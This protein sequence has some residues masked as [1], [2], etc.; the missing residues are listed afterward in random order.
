MAS[1]FVPGAT[2]HTK[3]G[4]SYVV[5]EVEDG[6]VYCRTSGGAETEFTEAALFTGAEWAAKSDGRRDLFYTRLRQAKAYALP[7]GSQDRATSDTLLKKIERLSPGILDYAAFIT[8]ARV[9]R[10][11]G[12]DALVDD[13]SVVKCR[14]V[15]DAAAAEIRLGLV[16]AMLGILPAALV[17]AGR[18]GDNLMRA[19]IEKGLASQA[20]AFDEFLDRPRR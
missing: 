7:T 8:A 6:I 1:R 16:A 18:L 14:D 20:E 3:D 12:D 5:D 13:L 9:M 10:E 15:F 2:V 4:R 19:L 17:D 11:N